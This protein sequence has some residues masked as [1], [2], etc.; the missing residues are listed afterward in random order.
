LSINAGTNKSDTLTKFS[1]EKHPLKP[2]EKGPKHTDKITEGTFTGELAPS[3][4]NDDFSSWTL[5]AKAEHVEHVPGP[6]TI[7]A[8][9][10]AVGFGVLCQRE[11]ARKRCNK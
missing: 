1:E 7:I 2:G 6:L 4:I 9:S 8:S 11:Y 3:M 10:L 5:V